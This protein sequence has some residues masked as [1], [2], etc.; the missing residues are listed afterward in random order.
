MLIMIPDG[1]WL[2]EQKFEKEGP[3]KSIFYKF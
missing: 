3:E 1:I 2:Y